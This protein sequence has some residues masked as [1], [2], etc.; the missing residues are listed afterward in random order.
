MIRRGNGHVTAIAVGPKTAC[1][2]FPARESVFMQGSG[3]HRALNKCF[4][5]HIRHDHSACTQ[6]ITLRSLHLPQECSPCHSTTACMTS[7]EAQACC[8]K[9]DANVAINAAHNT[10]QRLP[11]NRSTHLC[12]HI[13]AVWSKTPDS[14][15]FRTLYTSQDMHISGTSEGF[16]C[17]TCS[18]MYF[19]T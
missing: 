6:C 5:D 18:L 2:M 3:V 8:R 19:C 17:K 14:H 16:F 15:L 9:S 4:S 7:T 11:S 12:M 13:K 10:K 1:S